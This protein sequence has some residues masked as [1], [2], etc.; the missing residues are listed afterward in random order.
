MAQKKSIQKA[1]EMAKEQYAEF[2]VNTE[3][4]LEQFDKTIISMHCWQVDDVG[5]F[6][7]PDSALSGGIQV[8]GNYPGKASTIQQAKQ[9]YEKI[10]SLLPGKQRLSLHAIYGD[11][12]SNKADRDQ[13]E[14]RHFETWVDW[15]KK[16]EIGL[17]FN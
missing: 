16:M 2:G 3:I 17:D 9:D 8:T 15:A 10:M 12:T 7:N 11:F 13:I 4:V 1:Y 14:P 6:E 5:G